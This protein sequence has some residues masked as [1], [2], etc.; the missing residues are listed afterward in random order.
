M[1]PQMNRRSFIQ[2]GI[3]PA[4]LM[5]LDHHAFATHNDETRDQIADRIVVSGVE[6]KTASLPPGLSLDT[7]T[8]LVMARPITSQI[9]YRSPTHAWEVRGTITPKGDYLVMAPI[10]E[11]YGP[12]SKVN[13]L[14][15]FRSRD[16]GKTWTGPTDPMKTSYSM[17]GF[18]PLIPK[19]SNRLY[20]F[21]TQAIPALQEGKENAP[22]GFR[23]S[24]D[25]G[26]TWSDVHLIKPE[27]DPNFKG[28]SVM[29]MC[30]T[31]SGVWLLGSHEATWQENKLL[32]TRQYVLR[33]ANQGKTWMVLP[34]PRPEGWY[35]ASK[36]RMDEGRPISLGGDHV[37][38][39]I[40]TPEGHLWASWSDDAGMTWST[41]EPT[42]LI[43]PDAPPMLFHMPDGKTLA[44]FHHNSSGDWKKGR[45]E[46]WVS[47]STDGG[48]HWKAPRFVL[49]IASVPNTNNGFY[50]YQC[51]YLDAFCDGEQMH[52]FFPLRWNTVTH[53]T[54]KASALQTMLPKS[55]LEKG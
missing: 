39:M 41:P 24:D 23:F 46:V 19:G 38:L 7:K 42:S 10:G 4:A 29:R 17:H 44:C 12:P 13:Y 31:A 48:H 52:L 22:I 15:A 1:K 25:D 35:V 55:D 18:I 33:S 20:A 5:L 47:F 26:Y 34:H 30:E 43:H 45:S 40:R 49:A 11:H 54:V 36:G 9:I 14:A 8:G 53:L 50:D 2:A 6:L 3:V 27:N 28:M 51:S 32:S 16:R 21:G 37:L